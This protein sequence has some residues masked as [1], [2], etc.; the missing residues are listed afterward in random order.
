MK[1]SKQNPRDLWD[2]IQC[3]DIHIIGNLEGEKK[4]KGAEKYLKKNGQKV[5]L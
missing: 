4:E 3:T 1:K 5:I 2:T